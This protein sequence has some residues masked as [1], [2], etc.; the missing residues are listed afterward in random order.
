MSG[1]ISQK[2]V[3][4]STSNFHTSY[5]RLPARSSSKISSDLDPDP[6]LEPDIENDININISDPFNW[7]AFKLE[8]TLYEHERPTLPKCQIRCGSRS[9]VTGGSKN[10]KSKNTKI[11]TIIGVIDL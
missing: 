1:R 6:E 2:L 9:R 10:T 5:I 7:I 11:V 4:G 3:V 8:H